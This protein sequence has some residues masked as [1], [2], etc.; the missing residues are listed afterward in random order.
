VTWLVL[1][2]WEIVRNRARK[3]KSDGSRQN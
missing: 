3:Q 1:A 2:I